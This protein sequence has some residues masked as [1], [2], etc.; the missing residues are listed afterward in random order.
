[1]PKETFSQRLDVL[2]RKQGTHL[3]VGLDPDPTKLPHP[4]HGRRTADALATFVEGIVEATRPSCTAYKLQLAS[5]LAFGP[6]GIGAIPAVVRRIG[7]GRLR[8]LDL[9]AGDIPNTMGLYAKAVF[10]RLGFDA[11]TVSP[12]LGWESVEAVAQDPAR[13]VF[14]LAHTSNP[15]ARDLQERSVDGRP[16]WEELLQGIRERAGRGNLGAVVGATFPEALATARKVLGEDVPLLVPGVGSQG[17]DLEASLANGRGSGAGAMLI[18]SSR[19]I[20]FASSGDDWKE[21]ARAEATRLSRAM[22]VRAP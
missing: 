3:C 15:G 2:L 21:A 12:F 9:K 11:M 8:I 17:G 5:F 7:E 1:M 16:I 20:L 13:G 22:A 4:L 14:V 19:G 18:N 6:E 10:E